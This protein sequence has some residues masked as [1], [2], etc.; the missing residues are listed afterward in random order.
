[1]TGTEATCKTGKA[2]LP[3]IRLA[4]DKRFGLGKRGKK[5]H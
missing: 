5:V 1:M 3:R 4:G 2:R